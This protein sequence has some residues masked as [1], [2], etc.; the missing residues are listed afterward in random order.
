MA[1]IENTSFGF[2]ECSVSLV[3]RLF[4]ALNCLI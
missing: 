4:V 3:V 1:K 2:D